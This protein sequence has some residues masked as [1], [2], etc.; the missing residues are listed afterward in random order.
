MKVIKRTKKNDIATVYVAETENKQMVEFVE[1]TQPPFSIKEKWILMVSLLFGCPVKCKFCDA[2]GDYNGKL[3]AEQIMFQIDYMIKKRF[4]TNFIDVDKFKI[5][6]ARMGEPS[7]N[8]AVLEVL[9]ELPQKYTFKNF[10]PSV[11]TIAPLGLDDFF[12]SLLKIKDRLYRDNFQLQF[13]IHSANEKQRNNLTPLKKWDFQKIAEY[14]NQFFNRGN[15]KIT[16]NFAL[17][18]NSI[19][20]PQTLLKYFDPQIFLIKVTPVNP[21]FNAKSNN[22]ESLIEEDF[23]TP[24]IIHDLKAAGFEVILSYGELEENKIGS[25][26]GQYI[27][28]LKNKVPLDAYS[29]PLENV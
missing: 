12:F 4:P 3:T 24:E 5:Q 25:N 2:G 7:F 16:L 28:S 9:E 11:S 19:V 18:K 10:I 29:Y 27:Y 20:D 13:S 26:C 15:R 1:S 21:T 8:K 6:F 14:G 22:I 23:E 17:A